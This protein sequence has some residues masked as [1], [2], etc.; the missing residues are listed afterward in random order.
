MK[1]LRRRLLSSV[2]VG[3][4]VVSVGVLVFVVTSTE[5]PVMLVEAEQTIR[6]GDAWEARITLSSATAGDTVEVTLFNGLQRLDAVL[7]LGTGG[8]ALWQIPEGEITQAGLSLLLVHSGTAETRVPL[9]V[10]PQPPHELMLF[11]TANVIPAYGEGETTLLVLSQDMYGNPVALPA[12]QR[13]ASVRFPNDERESVTLTYYNGLAWSSLASQGP[14]GRV[15]VQVRSQQ[16]TTL[17][18]LLQTAA[19]AALVMLDISPTCVLSDGR[20]LITLTAEISDRRGMPVVDG[21]LITFAWDGG[22][23]QGQTVRGHAEI[24]LPAPTSPG[25]FR[26]TA[27][28]NGLSSAPVMLRVVSESCT[29]AND[30]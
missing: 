3:A 12:R 13:T 30:N 5:A 27:E 14:P 16:I 1:H 2:V 28:I 10:H 9:D 15:R 17:L 6:A 19:P 20:D 7:V 23:G 8:T 4:V 26:Y 18:E 29:D 24:R 22:F 21:T 25:L 11:T